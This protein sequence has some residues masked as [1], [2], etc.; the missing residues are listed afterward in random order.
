MIATTSFMVR[1]LFPWVFLEHVGWPPGGSLPAQ[2]WHL[3]GQMAQ[4]SCRFKGKTFG[5]GDL[6]HCTGAIVRQNGVSSPAAS[7]ASPVPTTKGTQNVE[8]IVVLCIQRP[9]TGPFSGS[10][11]PRPHHQGNGPRRYAGLDRGHVRLAAGGEIPGLIPGGSG[12]PSFRN[13]A[14]RRRWGRGGGYGAAI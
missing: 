8:P 11:A 6:N 2:I 1:P 4:K 10:P 9:A 14:A 5:A 12:P 3:S 13:R 7:P